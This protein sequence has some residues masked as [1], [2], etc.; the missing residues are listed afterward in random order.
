MSM[1]NFEKLC[2]V[3]MS[4]CNFEKLSGKRVFV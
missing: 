2:E 3:N 4:M 1:W